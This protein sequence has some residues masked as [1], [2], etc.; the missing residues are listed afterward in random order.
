MA[1]TQ[2]ITEA[3]I[4][5]SIVKAVQN[6]FKTMMRREATVRPAAP[7]SAPAASYQLMGNVGFAG[8]AN[9]VVYLCLTDDFA[10]FATGEIL[11]MTPGEVEMHGFEV[12]KDAIGEITNMTAGGFKNQLCDVGFPCKL[13]L[14]TIVRGKELSVAALKGTTRYVYEFDCAGHRLTADIQLKSETSA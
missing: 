2:P 10:S 3:L 5:D 9:G 7:E 11:G 12:V 13:T 4:R 1:V 6:V 14:P 8:E